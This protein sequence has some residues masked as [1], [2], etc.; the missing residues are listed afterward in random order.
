ME[1]DRRSDIRDVSFE[2]PSCPEGYSHFTFRVSASEL[3]I[4]VRNPEGSSYMC[5]R[6]HRVDWR[7]AT[8]SRIVD[9]DQL[10]PDNRLIPYRP[11]RPVGDCGICG[12]FTC[13]GN[14]S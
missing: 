3:S 6:G 7:Q 1:T 12:G 5:P 4:M 2:C 8:E 14:C 13:S 11:S 10:V 9:E